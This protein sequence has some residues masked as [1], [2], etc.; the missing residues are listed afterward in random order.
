MFSDGLVFSSSIVYECREGYYA[1]GLL[2]RHCSVNGTWTGSD[3]E[4]IGEKALWA[5]REMVAEATGL[6]HVKEK[7]CPWEIGKAGWSGGM[8]TIQKASIY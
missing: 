1:S 5:P 6:L 8:R 3:P 4:C 7:S 2:S